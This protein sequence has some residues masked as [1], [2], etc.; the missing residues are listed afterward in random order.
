MYI[1]EGAIGAGKS[2]LL[3]LLK[4]HVPEIMVKKEP[5][6]AWSDETQNSLLKKFYKDPVRWAYTFEKATLFE[7]V[8]NHLDYQLTKE[9]NLV[10]ERSIYSGHYIFAKNSYEQNFLTELEWKMYQEWFDFL[11][12]RCMTPKGFI[13]I[14]AQP[15]VSYS[16][17]KKRARSGE[18]AISLEYLHQI[19]NKHEQLFASNNN[20][21]LI[22][23]IPVLTLD[24]DKDF[25]KNSFYTN[26][27]VDTVK[28]FILSS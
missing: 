26:Q 16:R 14:K 10:V 9:S 12:G 5:V 20:Y 15:E 22:K 19:Y 8:K 25:E 23:N 7:R 18:E 6:A 24:V 11:V 1:L 17:I 21:K 27:H 2:T 3:S 13:Y 28:K 4:K